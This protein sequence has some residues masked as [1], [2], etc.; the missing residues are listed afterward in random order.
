MMSETDIFD[1]FPNSGKMYDM[2]VLACHPDYRGRGIATQLIHQAL[3][4]RSHIIGVYSRWNHRCGS[5]GIKRVIE[6]NII[7][8]LALQVRGHIIGV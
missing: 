4:V 2:H 5:S 8:S 1:Q 6:I 7:H 3:Q